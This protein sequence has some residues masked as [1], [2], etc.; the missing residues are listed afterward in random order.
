VFTDEDL[1]SSATALKKRREQTK[2]ER[3]AGPA[4]DPALEEAERLRRA[5]EERQVNEGYEAQKLAE[6]EWR[7]RAGASR[8]ALKSAEQAVAALE[9]Q[10][11]QL[12]G[13]I[14]MSTD[15]NQILALQAKQRKVAA[16]LE[17]ARAGVVAARQ[18]FA[19]LEEEARR[20]GIS[21]SW[22][23]P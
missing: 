14:M 23:E 18:S 1:P 20:K 19:E 9:E 11:R 7:Q 16:D 6:R 22:L 10:A 2:E 21:R 13:E 15:T 8:D 5:E 4:V 17:A 12:A 3:E